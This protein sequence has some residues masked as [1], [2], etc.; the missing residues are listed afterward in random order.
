[1]IRLKLFLTGLA[2]A[3]FQTAAWAGESEGAEETPGLFSGGLWTSFWTLVVFFVLLIVLGKV[4]WKPLVAALKKRE[5]RIRDDLTSA[6]QNREETEKK[7]AE[8]KQQLADADMKA[9]ELISQTMAESESI[10]ER[11]IAG[12]QAEVTETLKD[13]RIQLEH[14]KRQAM[15]ELYAETVSLAGQLAG[16]ILQREVN[17]EDH[18]Q[19]I[20]QGLKELDV[21]ESKK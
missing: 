16:K 10:R 15:K 4:A 13:A 11:I 7:L 12:A 17:A 3:A 21:N 19:L 8:L 2:V 20:E 1:M 9:R 14:A 5:D 6:R 18:R